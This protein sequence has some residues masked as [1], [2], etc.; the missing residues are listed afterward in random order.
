M[1]PLEVKPQNIWEYTQNKPSLIANDM[2]QL[3]N[4]P[5][6]ATL[7]IL[8]ARGVFKWLSV[9]RELIKIKNIWKNKIVKLNN[10]IK[11]L[12]S[13]VKNNPDNPVKQYSY[14][15]AK[16]YKK[17]LEDCRKEIRKMCHSE[18]WRTPDFDQKALKIIEE[19]IA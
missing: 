10:E 3:F 16:G 15:Y 11:I 17:A 7:K 6:L 2:E 1:N 5:K 18:R 8:M 9:R 19:D 13:F 12:K 14:G 4:V